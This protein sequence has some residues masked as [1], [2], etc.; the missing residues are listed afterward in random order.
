MRTVTRKRQN[1]KKKPDPGKPDPG[2]P[3]PEGPDKAP[4]DPD[5]ERKKK[6]KKSR[7]ND[8]DDDWVPKP[9]LFKLS[10]LPNAE[11]YQEWWENLHYEKTGDWN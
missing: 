8:S 4:S 5:S 7:D 3:G 1:P 6:H 11:K 10:E 2:P 9:D